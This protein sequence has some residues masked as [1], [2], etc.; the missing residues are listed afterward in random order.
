MSELVNCGSNNGVAVVGSMMID[1]VAYSPRIPHV[2][3]TIFGS[4]FEKNYGGKGANQA[5]M[6]NNL[7]IPVSMFCKIGQDSFGEEYIQH[8]GSVGVTVHALKADVGISTGIACITVDDNG[9]N[10]I[11]IIPGANIAITANDITFDESDNETTTANPL[12]CWANDIL[13][14]NVIVC[15]NEISRIG[16]ETVLKMVF[17]YNNSIS[18]HSK[19]SKI[20]I[21]NPAPA[22]KECLEYFAYADIICPNEVELAMLT[23]M[24]TNTDIEIEC[25]V[26]QL[27]NHPTNM[28]NTGCQVAIVTLGARGVCLYRKSA[29]SSGIQFI[30]APSVKCIDTVG[31]GDC[32][33]G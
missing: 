6:V 9:S 12:K 13:K 4:K 25:A 22:T 29:K 26:K 1:F 28:K 19:Q 20:T 23:D 11:V 3:E 5:V 31:A 7:G 8:L 2:G 33:I 15:Q 32:F 18:N 21:F 14:A 24:P 16:T 27:L 10:S 17:D 30:S